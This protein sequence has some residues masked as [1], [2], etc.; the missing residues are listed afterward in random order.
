MDNTHIR[1]CFIRAV[2]AFKN[3]PPMLKQVFH[4]AAVYKNQ[5]VLSDSDMKMLKTLSSHHEVLR[6]VDFS[7]QF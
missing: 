5:G 7:K 6:R 1:D 3:R 2:H 4:D